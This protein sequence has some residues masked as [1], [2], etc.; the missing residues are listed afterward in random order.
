MDMFTFTSEE[1]LGYPSNMEEMLTPA[2]VVEYR[3]NNP[4]VS[5]EQSSTMPSN[6]SSVNILE[7]I[8]ETEETLKSDAPADETETTSATVTVDSNP[9]VEASA[10]VPVVTTSSEQS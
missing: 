9:V 10:D 3:R 6:I 2:Y 1:L 4:T 8:H 7:T 5:Q